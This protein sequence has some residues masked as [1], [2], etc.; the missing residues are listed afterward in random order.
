MLRRVREEK[1]RAYQAS[2]REFRETNAGW[3]DFVYMGE[4][5]TYFAKY[6]SNYRVNL[7]VH[8]PLKEFGWLDRDRVE[9]GLKSFLRERLTQYS[10]NE[11]YIND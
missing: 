9:R 3:G 4:Q 6:V 5:G 8:Y 7:D 10:I 2:S 1:E 11:I